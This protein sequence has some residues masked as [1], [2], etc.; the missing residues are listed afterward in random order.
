MNP[1]RPTQKSILPR[2]FQAWE[3]KLGAKKRLGIQFLQFA[4]R[5]AA[6]SRLSDS[7]KLIEK[8][9]IE[10]QQN[11][12]N[13]AALPPKQNT[14]NAPEICP[15]MLNK[16]FEASRDAIVLLDHKGRI[17]HWNPAA[18]E[19]FGYPRE[20]VLGQ[21]LHE[22]LMPEKELAS[23]RQGIAY[24]KQTGKGRVIGKTLELAV[25]NKDGGEFPIE[26]S[27]SSVQINGNWHAVGIAR[28][29][30]QRKQTEKALR[31]GERSRM[32]AEMLQR[33]LEASTSAINGLIHALSQ[34]FLALIGY[35]DLLKIYPDNPHFLASLEEITNDIQTY[36]EVFNLFRFGLVDNRLVNV[37]ELA[38]T[39]FEN[40]CRETS[41]NDSRAH[42]IL[43]NDLKEV[44]APLAALSLIL[45]A[46]LRNA[47][48]A[49]Q[50]GGEVTLS[51]NEKSRYW[52]EGIEIR[53]IDNGKGIAPEVE[54]KIFRP[55]FSTDPF[56]AAKKRGLSLTLVHRA[57][58]L[59][60]GE[61]EVESAPGK[62]TTF[63]VW[64]PKNPPKSEDFRG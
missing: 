34:K 7:A 36:F 12:G 3:M 49:I 10:L 19:I 62:G 55:F 25:K 38:T 14:K 26:L 23:Y 1:T 63:K 51:L 6:S 13:A 2:A 43:A 20:D 17:K 47:F 16:I 42:L 45:D 57:V 39:T 33:E 52:V 15:A 60:R 24:F 4:K 40:F 9:I 54:E 50:E 8:A 44:N 31:E 53:I 28:D 64:I 5:L 18:E 61:I 22:I 48:D 29:I 56:G 11:A 35:V 41:L 32:M 30:S 46:P 58:H 27:V 37:A 59:L 21:D